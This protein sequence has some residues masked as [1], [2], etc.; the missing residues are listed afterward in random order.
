M[1]VENALGVQVQDDIAKIAV[2]SQPL[3][4]G[5]E[6]NYDFGLIYIRFVGTH[7]EYDKID[8]SEV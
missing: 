3:E 1:P 5:D 7:K 4:L 2:L 8:A 6:E